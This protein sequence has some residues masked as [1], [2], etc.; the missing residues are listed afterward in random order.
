MSEPENSKMN[1]LIISESNYSCQYFDEDFIKQKN[2][3]SK[4]LYN[5]EE[6]EREIY[7]TQQ[8]LSEKM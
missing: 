2:L 4:K 1:N 8:E 7:D 3:K 5:L 6:K